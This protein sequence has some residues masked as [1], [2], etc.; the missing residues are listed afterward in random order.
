MKV[1]YIKFSPA[2]NTTAFIT[3]HVDP[4]DYVEIANTLMSHE[5]VHAEQ[6]GFLVSPHENNAMLRIEM[7]GGEFCGNAILAAAAY[8]KYAELTKADRFLIESSGSA[9]PLRCDVNEKSPVLYEVKA[10]MPAPD[11]K[12]DIMIPYR[13][14]TIS[15]CLVQLDGITHFITNYWPLEEEFADILEVVKETVEDKAIG[16]IPYRELTNSEYEIRPLVHVSET[17]NTFFEHA[18]GSG[19]LALGVYLAD[20]TNN[21]TF[22]VQQPGGTIH[23]DIGN[24]NYISTDVRI[25]CEGIA[26][27]PIG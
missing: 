27:L 2:Q 19:T 15:G 17:G 8:C 5:Y 24:K 14:Q 11:A 22:H 1:N 23:V 3:S 13:D 10:E 4:T 12:K 26:H 9:L 20:N 16:I 21:S 18:C 7:S 25:T 6:A